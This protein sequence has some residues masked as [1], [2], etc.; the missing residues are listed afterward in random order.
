ME[1]LRSTELVDLIVWA[2]QRQLAY[3]ISRTGRKGQQALKNAV[4]E[5]LRLSDLLKHAEIEESAPWTSTYETI[6]NESINALRIGMNSSALIATEI[7]KLLLGSHHSIFLVTLDGR[8]PEDNY[9]VLSLKLRQAQIFVA[10][11][12]YVRSGDAARAADAAKSALN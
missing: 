4:G 11:Y 3:E 8:E 2:V 9:V 12:F 1:T 10:K 7:E 6:P 5:L